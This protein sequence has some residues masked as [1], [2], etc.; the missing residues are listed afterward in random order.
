MAA[1]QGGKPT[2]VAK[3]PVGGNP[4]PAAPAAPAQTAQTAPTAP[5]SSLTTDE[6]G[7]M[8]VLAQTFDSMMG[9]DPELDKLLLQYQKLRPGAIDA[10]P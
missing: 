8:G 1:M 9:Q 5:A 2:Q 3:P 6:E 4:K 10:G 7:E